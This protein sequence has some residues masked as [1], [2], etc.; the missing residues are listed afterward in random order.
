MKKAFIYILLLSGLAGCEDQE[1]NYPDYDM[2]AVY[3]PLQLPLRTLSLGED[4]VDNSMD[5]ELKFDIGIAIGGMYKNNKDW[6]VDYVV[7]T[8]LTTG[9]TVGGLPL[10]S[11]PEAYYS[12][13]PLNTMVIP[14]G[15]FNGRIQVQL[16]QNF[17]DDP[18][19][20]AGRYAVPLRITGT[21]ADSVLSGVPAPNTDIPDRRI[22]ANWIAGQTPKDW[23]LFGIKYINAYHGNY[24]QRGRNIRY[25]G[26]VPLDT[27]IYKERFVERDQRVRFT[28]IAK[29][30]IVTNGVSNR[31]SSGNNNYS[32]ELTF[33]NITGA[34]GAITISPAAGS[35]YSVTGSGQFFERAESVEGFAELIFQSMH[36]NYTYTDGIY[37]HQVTDTLIFRDRAIKYE[38][39]TIVV[40]PAI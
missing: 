33:A 38:E 29:D 27:A 39:L 4:R 18:I 30:R 9:V 28:T 13:S 19:A 15:S 24:L 22:P 14:N 12:L 23:V 11:L 31:I 35:L 40:T 25:Q 5:R 6:T 3:F 16:N 37:T 32:M 26:G 2:Q 21:S 1:I 17:L 20:I 34:S 7:D 10:L 8:S 36:L